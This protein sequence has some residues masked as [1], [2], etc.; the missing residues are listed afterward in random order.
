[1]PVFRDVVRMHDDHANHNMLANPGIPI[2]KRKRG[3]QPGN[4]NRL[5][6]GLR[7]KE[8]LTL[9]ARLRAEIRATRAL[10]KLSAASPSPCRGE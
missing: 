8:W 6:H 7:S 9:R 3:A 1:M 10:L 2:V 5:R 4:K